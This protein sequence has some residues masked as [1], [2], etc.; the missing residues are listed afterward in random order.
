MTVKHLDPR[1]VRALAHPLRVRLLGSLRFDG[2]GTASILGERLG[3]SSGATS[4]HLRVLADHGF[5]EEDPSRGRGR[6]R[7][8][9][10]AHDA[11]SWRPEQF[12]GDP[13]AEAAEQWLSGFV[14][15]QGMEWLDDWLIRRSFA[16]PTWV[17]ASG[18]NDYR[19]V[20]TPRELRALT[21]ELHEVIRRH[22]EAAEDARAAAGQGEGDTTEPTDARPVR[23][24]LY[25]FP[26]QDD[27]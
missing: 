19:L 25:A 20:M 12:R 2:P 10:S 9:R 24:L 5:I 14:A 26:V 13:D 15:R 1:S 17:A 6:E 4:Y 21:D 3:E 18:A 23:L 27:A 11:T 8:W 16:D 7:W 22:D